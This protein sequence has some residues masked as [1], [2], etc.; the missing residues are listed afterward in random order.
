MIQHNLVVEVM[1]CAS[2]SRHLKKFIESFDFINMKPDTTLLGDLRGN[3][4]AEEGKQYAVYFIDDEY[5]RL[6]L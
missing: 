3:V 2:N 4:L 6:L 1:R 5:C